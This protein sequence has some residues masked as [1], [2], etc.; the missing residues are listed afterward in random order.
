MLTRRIYWTISFAITLLIWGILAKHLLFVNQT[1]QRDNFQLF[2]QETT[3]NYLKGFWESAHRRADQ[4]PISVPTGIFVQSISWL[5]A[6]SFLVSGYL[7]QHYAN[8]D[9]RALS[10]GFILPEAVELK[11]EVAYRIENQGTETI[12]WYFEGKILQRFD[13]SRYPFDN[14]VIRLRLWHQDFDQRALLTPSFSSYD[15]MDRDGTF[16]LDPKISF[17]GYDILGTYFRYQHTSYDTNFGFTE[18]TAQKEFPELYFNIILK[19]DVLDAIII[20]VLPL[21]AVFLLCFSSLLA[22]TFDEKKRDIYNFR[23]LEILTQSAALFFVLLL[24]HIHLRESFAGV[25]IVYLE[26]IYVAVYLSIVYITLNAYLVV[27][28]ELSDY[29]FYHFVKY[30]DNL[31]PKVAFL[32]FFSLIV[33]AVSFIFF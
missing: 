30:E 29:A 27:H 15:R 23:F 19:R 21:I 12:G 7:W 22:N 13:Y 9:G 10:H 3:D 1:Y 20:H 4:I 18:F 11:Q 6:N 25:G 8:A 2:D 26:Y 14:K 17:S 33:L 28:A 31:L 32:P 16:G 5:D 24:A